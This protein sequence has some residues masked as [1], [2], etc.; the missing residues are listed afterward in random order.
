MKRL[1]SVAAALF[2]L[3]A[4]NKSPELPKVEHNAP[5][6]AP[7]PPKPEGAP[8]APELTPEQIKQFQK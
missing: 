7:A 5:I 6:V 1:I 4:C 8:Q 3:A 2:V